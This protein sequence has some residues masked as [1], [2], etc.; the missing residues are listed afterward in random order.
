M[1]FE[2]IIKRLDWLEKERRKDKE[3][4]AALKEQAAS[5]ET[6]VNAAAKQ[7]K[8]LNKQFSEIS[9][10]AARFEQFDTMLAKQRADFAKL[11]EQSEKNAQRRER[12][13]AK[14]R[15]A[16]LAEI[17]KTI[18]ELK[19]FSPSELKKKFKEHSDVEQRLSNNLADLKQKVEEAVQSNQNV[20]QSWKLGEEARKNDLK[21]IADMQGELTAIRKRV[22]DSREKTKLNADSIRNIENRLTELLA[23]EMDRKQAQTA[24]IEQ[25][26]LAQVERD[27]AWKEWRAK[28][29]TFQQEAQAME[30]QVQALDEAL[31]GAK[32]AQETYV[33]LNTKLERRINE[34]TEMQRLAEDRLRQEWVTFKADDQKR[35]TGYSLSAEDSFRDL[36]KDMKKLEEQAARLEEITQ[37]LQDQLHQ[38]TDTTEQQLQELMNI[39]HE[40]MTAYERI[41]GHG[42]KAKK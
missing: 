20:M 32:K 4:I 41:M 26:A 18:A 14:R 38:T 36:R 6:S 15:Q 16:E 22:E 5:L 27:R 29:E 24:F 11:I 39:A 2:Q 35:W 37:L 33:E 12:E 9:A 10:G 7:I 28:Y 30:T 40:W 42:K 25:Q 23:T 17:N 34:V 8:A 31:R 3:V 1:E 13:A 21:R 19:V